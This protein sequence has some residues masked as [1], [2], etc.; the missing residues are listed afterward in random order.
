MYN[1][2][3]KTENLCN[4]LI[5]SVINEFNKINLNHNSNLFL[6][7]LENFIVLKGR[8][9]INTPLNYQK[10]FKE[11]TLSLFD[12][13]F[14][15]VV[16]DLIEY[17]KN[18]KIESI[19]LK[20]KY[21][22]TQPIQDKINN[23]FQFSDEFYGKSLISDKIYVIYFNY[24]WY[25]LSQNFMVKDMEVHFSYDKEN[26]LDLSWENSKLEVIT[27]NSLVTSRWLKSA[28]LD[29]YDLNPLHIKNHLSLKNYDFEKDILSDKKCW[30]IRDRVNELVFL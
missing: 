22:K 16:I 25:N 20:L 8:T 30:E 29:L 12:K 21:D 2:L 26:I 17:N 24:I 19:N 3:F 6:I 27:K 7:D 1:N 9:T 23:V 10:I 15:L 28:I 4:L 11:K 18:P 13:D 14:N 5:N